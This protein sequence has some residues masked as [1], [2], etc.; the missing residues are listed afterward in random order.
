MWSVNYGLSGN[1]WKPL[2][3]GHGGFQQVSRNSK[4]GRKPAGNLRGPFP[5]IF[6]GFQRFL[7]NPSLTDHT[8]HGLEGLSLQI[9]P[10]KNKF[11]TGYLIA[12]IDK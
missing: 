8:V 10:K 2:E 12:K 3:T 7:D 9:L 11:A 5:E 1:L 6:R 4:T